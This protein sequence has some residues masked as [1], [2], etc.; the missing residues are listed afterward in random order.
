MWIPLSP[1]LHRAGLQS[2]PR[3]V[4]FPHS[5][6]S[7]TG[8][9]MAPRV[10]FWFIGFIVG[11]INNIPS[12]PTAYLV[13]S[14]ILKASHQRECSQLKSSLLSLY[15]TI[16]VCSV[17]CNMTL[18]SSSGEQP[19]GFTRVYIVVDWMDSEVDLARFTEW[20][21]PCLVVWWA[22]SCPAQFWNDG[23]CFKMIAY[24]YG[25]L[26]FSL[27][28]CGLVPWVLLLDNLVRHSQLINLFSFHWRG[29]KSN[30]S[31]SANVQ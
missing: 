15:F 14:G 30:N 6:G 12:A 8:W 4:R 17:F 20:T 21:Y 3:A 11:K 7:C 28:V 13:P 1:P 16:K 5:T 25:F 18:C 24:T 29:K 9:H 27:D 31:L 23:L 19:Q 22:H 26:K 2:N 10:S